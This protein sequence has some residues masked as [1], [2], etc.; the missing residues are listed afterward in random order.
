[1]TDQPDRSFVSTN[2]RVREDR[3]FVAGAGRYVADLDIPG[4]LHVALVASTA[5][6]AKILG[7]DATEA[8]AME[9]VVDVL[10]GEELSAAVT[11]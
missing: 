2:R 8:L 10:T 5:P 9:G 1:M 4:T 11:P 6:A 3:R 7:I